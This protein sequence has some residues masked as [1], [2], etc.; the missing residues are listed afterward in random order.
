MLSKIT[1]PT[2][3]IDRNKCLEN[4]N[5]MAQKAQSHNLR[6][7]PHFKTHQSIEIGRWFKD[8]SI[9]GITVSSLKMAEFF[10][11]DGWNSITIAFPVN[12]LE[13]KQI[14]ALADRIDLRVLVVNSDTVKYLDTKL[15]SK[16]G[17][18][19]EIDPSY[20]RSGITYLDDDEIKKLINEINV[21][22]K[23]TLFGFYAH[24]GH[25]YKSRSKDEIFDCSTPIVKELSKL[26]NK[27][28]LPVCFGDTPS[29]SV[30]DD[31]GNIDEISPG[32]FVF[33]DW[34]QTQIG[35]C[36]ADEIAVVMYCPVVAKY[37]SRNELLIHGG[38]VHFSKDYDV[39]S[40][41]K[42]Y[43]GQVAEQKE[44]SWSKP[45][46]DCYLKSISQ[47][48][49]VIACT[50][51]FYEQTSV[52]DLVAIFPIHSCL[53]ADLNGSYLTTDG[54]KISHLSEKKI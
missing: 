35:S 48:H 37:P 16:L 27:Y 31:F 25:S 5:M 43:F 54:I 29:C 15:T 12:I 6:F 40:D 24:A 8:F 4:I 33:Y 10:A 52:G 32:N 3:V 42:S 26:K 7:R 41:G 1:T 21:S 36:T 39:R 2:L 51:E 38:A 11:D 30:L 53:T 19:I 20:G 44:A 46:E 9:D 47:E 14:D 45:L 17:V 22:E 34:I 50:T 18:Y 13:Y 28:N 49:G 23:L